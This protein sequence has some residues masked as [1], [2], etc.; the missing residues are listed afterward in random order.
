[1]EVAVRA[2]EL[3]DPDDPAEDAVCALVAFAT[4]AVLAGR[5]AEGIRRLREAVAL[6]DKVSL[7]DADPFV[8][9]CAAFAGLFI[10]ETRPQ[11]DLLDRAGEQARDR[12][13]TAALPTILF[14]LARDAASTDRWQLARAQYE[15]CAR[16]ARETAQVTLLAGSTAGLA[17]LD[18]LEGRADECR[19]HAAEGRAIAEQY[20]VSAF[21]AWATI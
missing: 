3:L 18:A 19:A 13:P 5:G 11:R 7:E 6:F 15:E 8:L 2:V 16:V 1:M 21:V 10:R 9:T 12:A 14:L 17:W 20:G 4:M